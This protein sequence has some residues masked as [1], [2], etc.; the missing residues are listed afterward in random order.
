MDLINRHC[1]SD[2]TY[3]AYEWNWTE[4]IIYILFLPMISFYSRADGRC[5]LCHPKSHNPFTE[6]AHAFHGLLRLTFPWW[7]LVTDSPTLTNAVEPV[8]YMEGLHLN[9]SRAAWQTLLDAGYIRLAFP[10][11]PV[12]ILFQYINNVG[13]IFDK[14]KKKS[15]K[16]VFI[17]T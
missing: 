3:Q 17:N 12:S 4:I 7:F 2:E 15:L 11:I 6:H 1:Q 16:I 8:D 14:K 10:T 5:F 13:L 9:G